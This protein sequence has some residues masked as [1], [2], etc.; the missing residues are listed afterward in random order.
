MADKQEMKEKRI[1][2]EELEGLLDILSNDKLDH[3]K[4]VD[5]V[6]MRLA[7]MLGQRSSK[8]TQYVQTKM[9]GE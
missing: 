1:K 9:F 5:T 2:V 8:A 4:R 3:Q 6:A 7:W